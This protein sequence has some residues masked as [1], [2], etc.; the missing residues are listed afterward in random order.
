MNEIGIVIM[1]R[2][3]SISS[4]DFTSSTSRRNLLIT[5]WTLAKVPRGSRLYRT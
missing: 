5:G 4:S 3:S 2:M 1:Y